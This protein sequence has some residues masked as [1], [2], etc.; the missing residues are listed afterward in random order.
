MLVLVIAPV[1]CA[2]KF[3]MVEQ[4]ENL[5]LA[6]NSEE[7]SLKRFYLRKYLIVF[8]QEHVHFR[9][10][11]LFSICSLFDISIDEQWQSLQQKNETPFVVIEL[12]NDGAAKQIA[13]RSILIKSI[14]KLY[15]CADNLEELVEILKQ[16][17]V[18]D[19]YLQ[20]MIDDTFKINVES[21][22]KKLSHEKKLHYIE[23]LSFLPHTGE[24]DLRN[25]GTIFSLLLDFSTEQM[26]HQ[27][28]KLL[29]GRLVSN[30]QRHL[31]KKYSLKTRH[32][33]GN[34]SMDAQLA[35]LMANMA[36][37]KDDSLVYDPFV[38][39][40]SILVACSHFGSYSCGSDIDRTLLLGRG[41]PSRAQ[42]KG[43]WRGKDESV[44][45]NFKMY[46][47][48]H[49]YIDVWMGD[50]MN[51]ALRPCPM[52]DAIVTDPPYGIREG[53]RKLAKAVGDQNNEVEEEIEGFKLPSTQSCLLSDAIFN[54]LE[55]AVAFLVLHGRLV[56]WLPTHRSTFS[57]QNIPLHPCLKLLYV[58]E[59]NLSANVSRQLITMEKIR[60]PQKDD[61]VSINEHSRMIHDQFRNKYF[62]MTDMP[63]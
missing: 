60:E 32:F 38:G 59:Q 17:N 44:R 4:K 15:G 53:S 39:T 11:E 52:F 3:K 14:F 7:W 48:L 42:A 24:V 13:S 40:G 21:F 62:K 10:E 9:L 63:G 16:Y 31:I 28:T 46:S 2:L 47:L 45:L 55:F 61:A 41:H 57:L 18:N 56:F 23:S 1:S 50:Q 36:K 35:L 6:S 5:D 33:I 25:P 51:T 54:L 43:K 20:G 26:L 22:N 49:R 12:E 58:S 30:G 29:F 27:L 34:T 19:I 8:A 37:C